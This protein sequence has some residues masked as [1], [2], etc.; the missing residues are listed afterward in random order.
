MSRR[1]ASSAKHSSMCQSPIFLSKV[2][3]PTLVLLY[4]GTPGG[5]FYSST[6]RQT[7]RREMNSCEYRLTVPCTLRPVGAS[8][9]SRCEIDTRDATQTTRT[10]GR[11]VKTVLKSLAPL[12]IHQ[13][14]T[15]TLPTKYLAL[16]MARM[17]TIAIPSQTRTRQG[18]R[19]PR[20]Q[21]QASPLMCPTRTAPKM[22]STPATA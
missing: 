9:L 7:F 11:S 18:L 17:M 19:H 20:R 13:T 16:A 8:P 6:S 3:R 15:T 1:C 2:I 4:P 12:P 5:R 21:S 22:H 10:S 14:L